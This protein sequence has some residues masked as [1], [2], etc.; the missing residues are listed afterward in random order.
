[1]VGGVEEGEEWLQAGPRWAEWR[2]SGPPSAGARIK[3]QMH[4]AWMVGRVPGQAGV[5][6]F[7]IWPPAALPASQDAWF[8]LAP[9]PR[10]S[11]LEWTSL[12]INSGP[13]HEEARLPSGSTLALGPEG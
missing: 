7:P 11:G 3:M 4:P 1:M 8:S 9:L 13:L 12:T 10:P 6:H 5:N 2:A